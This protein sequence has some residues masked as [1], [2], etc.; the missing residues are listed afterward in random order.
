MGGESLSDPEIRRR[1]EGLVAALQVFRKNASRVSVAQVQ[2]ALLTAIE[3]MDPEKGTHL[4]VVSDYARR[5]G[6]SPSGASRLMASLCEPPTEDGAPLLKSDRGPRGQR[7]EAFILS[8][9]GR[10]VVVRAVEALTDRRVE[11][12]ATHDF[13]TFALSRYAKAD[14][15]SLKIDVLGPRS[16]LVSPHEDALSSRVRA[17]CA[18]E[19]SRM[20]EMTPANEGIRFDFA[21][22]QDTSLFRKRW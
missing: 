21:T 22:K 5:L 20:P 15:E 10:D 17:W 7:A 8:K 2:A 3:T 18:K 4:P 13:L 11:K 9:E 16:L 19:L 14:T 6:L 12:F 1:M